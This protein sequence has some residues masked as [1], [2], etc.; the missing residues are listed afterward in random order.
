MSEVFR[1]EDIGLE[2][3]DEEVHR[4]FFCDTELGE[5]NSSEMHYQ[6]GSISSRART[7]IWLPVI[8]TNFPHS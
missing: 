8:N 5:F 4:I 3:M 2:Q 1:N 6:Q 7:R